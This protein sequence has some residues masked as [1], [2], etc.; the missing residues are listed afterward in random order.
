MIKWFSGWLN[1]LKKLLGL[2]TREGGI[3]L[4]AYY[5]WKIHGTNYS[6]IRKDVNENRDENSTS[7]KRCENPV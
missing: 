2:V 4:I 5:P 1:C 7:R 6:H 3:V